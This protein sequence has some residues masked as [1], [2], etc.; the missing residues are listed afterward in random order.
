ME[1]LVKVK[2]KVKINEEKGK[3]PLQ[4]EQY[5]KTQEGTSKGMKTSTMKNSGRKSPETSKKPITVG[6]WLWDARAQ[7]AGHRG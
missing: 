6:I 7:P 1:G 4:L 5:T 2:V 3:Q